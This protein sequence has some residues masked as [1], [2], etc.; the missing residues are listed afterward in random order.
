M[1]WDRSECNEIMEEYNAT[2]VAEKHTFSY[3]VAPDKW[4]R[5]SERIRVSDGSIF[6]AHIWPSNTS[7][8]F[9]AHTFENNAD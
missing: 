2:S 4:I 1:S 6:G 3:P 9:F 5:G 7:F 8:V